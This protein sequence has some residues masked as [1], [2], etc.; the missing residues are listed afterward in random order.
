MLRILDEKPVPSRE[1]GK[2]HKFDKNTVY[3][4]W[5]ATNTEHIYFIPKKIKIKTKQKQPNPKTNT[6]WLVKTWVS[7]QY[8]SHQVSALNT[9]HDSR[10]RCNIEAI[11]RSRGPRAELSQPKEKLR[12]N[13]WPN[14]TSVSHFTSQRIRNTTQCF[15]TDSQKYPHVKPER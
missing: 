11:P 14:Q 3:T 7:T 6:L 2:A 1:N 8:S 9:G 10:S 15:T 5:C 12:G 13:T 4:D